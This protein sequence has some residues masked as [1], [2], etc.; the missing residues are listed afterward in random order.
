MEQEK[1]IAALVEVINAPTRPP[2]LQP[3]AYIKYPTRE[4]RPQVNPDGSLTVSLALYGWEY[5]HQGPRPRSLPLVD[6][7]AVQAALN[8]TLTDGLIVVAVHDHRQ[9][10]QITIKEK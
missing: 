6:T 4:L 1:V 5:K 2:A 3:L 7:A 8:F 10:L 9:K